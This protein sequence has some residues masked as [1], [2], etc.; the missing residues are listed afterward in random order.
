MRYNYLVTFIGIALWALVPGFIAQK[1]GRSFAGYYFLSFLIS[2][3]IAM[4][5]TFCLKD[6]NYEHEN[7]QSN[8]ATLE[9]FESPYCD[10]E[11][12]DTVI[13]HR[14]GNAPDKNPISPLR[15]ISTEY[16][17]KCP[18]CGIEQKG[19]RTVCWNCSTPF[20]SEINETSSPPQTDIEDNQQSIKTCDSEES[21]SDVETLKQ[22]STLPQDIHETVTKE[23]RIRF[24]RKCGNSLSEDSEFCGKCGTKVIG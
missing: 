5:I 16:G 19:N 3:L 24:C 14:E 23:S 20:I 4:I 1:K 10:P 18:V 2:P 7:S 12:I 21:Q 9:K 6:I 22:D 13:G 11:Q 17:K 8:S 15:A